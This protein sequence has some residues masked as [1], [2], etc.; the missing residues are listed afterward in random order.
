LA[1]LAH[2]SHFCSNQDDKVETP[3]GAYDNG[4]LVLNQGGFGNGNASLSYVSN[5]FVTFQNNI[6]C[7]SKPN[8]Q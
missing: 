8:N 3:L 6:F 4:V 1:L 5:D 7:F 2:F